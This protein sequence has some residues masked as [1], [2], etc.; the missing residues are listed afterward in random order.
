MSTKKQ[1]YINESAGSTRIAITY[2]K[3]LIEMHAELPEHHRTVGN[4]YKGKIQ[5]VIPGMQAAFVDIGLDINAF[6]P[7]SEIGNYEGLSNLS[8]SEDDDDK[9]TTDNVSHD[10]KIKSREQ[11]IKNLKVNDEILVQVIK[12]PFSGKGPRVTTDISIPGSLL[13]LV[14]DA[15]YIGISRKISDKY[16]KRRLRRLAKKFQ[17]D[18]FGII[19]RTIAQGK[20]QNLLESDFQRV[21]TKWEELEKLTKE[22]DAPILIYK[23]FTTSDQVIRDLFTSDVEK[24]CVDSKVIY[25]RI[26]A[27]LKTV[28][29]E[30]LDKIELYKSKVPIFDNLDIEKQISQTLRPKVLLKSGAS[31][32]IEHTE[33]MVVVD[34]NSGKFIGKKNHEQNS[35]QINLEA[36]TEIARQLRLRDIGGLIVIDFIDL[37]KVENRKKVYEHFKKILKKDK[38]RVSLAEF[39]NFGLLEMTRERIKLNLLSSMTDECPLC[40]GIGRV[41]SKSMVLTNIENWLKS[42]KTKSSDRRLSL[43]INPDLKKYIDLN[44]KKMISSFMWKNWVYI[45]LIEDNNLSQTDFKVY[46]KKRKRFVTSDV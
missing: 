41:P 15:T 25:K 37:M 19:I 38:A 32:V 16:E 10:G 14:P 8:L 6:L 24:V 40:N 11:F 5:N 44:N 29:P 3:K 28:H 31:I 35:L 1:I 45:D 42:F 17:P 18:N 4:I 13:V 21:W 26:I 2:E 9:E 34:V 12:E 43:H 39:S 7:F 22:N 30:E 27:Y 46:S 20:N 23:D 36:A 33:A